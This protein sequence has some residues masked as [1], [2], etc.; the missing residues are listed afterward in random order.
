MPT[1]EAAFFPGCQD[2]T[3]RLEMMLLLRS[4]YAYRPVHYSF[5]VEK[6]LKQIKFFCNSERNDLKV[7][8]QNDISRPN[9]GCRI[10]SWVF[11]LDLITG[12]RHKTNF[13]AL[14]SCFNARTIGKQK[15]QMVQTNSAPA[16]CPEHI[17]LCYT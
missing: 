7:N 4:L 5:S 3:M 13:F 16:L 9:Q 15:E 11:R 17:F 2:P 6:N 10:D 8:L 14:K 1:A 12:N